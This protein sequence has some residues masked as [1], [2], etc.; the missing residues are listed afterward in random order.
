VKMPIETV[1]ANTAVDDTHYTLLVDATGW[2][3]T[4]TLPDLASFEKSIY[5]V[6]KIDSSVNTVTVTGSQNID[7]SASVVLSTQYQWNEFQGN[8][9]ERFITWSF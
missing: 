6:K 5:R 8:S 9:T 4:I 2:A 3:V 7:W 1:T